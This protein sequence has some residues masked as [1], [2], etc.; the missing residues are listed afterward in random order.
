M[1]LAPGLPDVAIDPEPLRQVLGNL[2]DNAH[3]A[4]AGR[5]SLV[6]IEA[7]SVELTELE[8]PE[9]L[10]TPCRAPV[11]VTVADNGPGL[12]AVA[13]HY[14]FREPFFT[15]KPSHRGLGLAATYGILKSYGGGI[16]LESAAQGG[17]IA[18]IYLPVAG[19]V[20]TPKRG[21]P[22]ALEP[23]MPMTGPAEKMPIAD[24][25]PL[26]PNPAWAT[27]EEAGCR[28]GDPVKQPVSEPALVSSSQ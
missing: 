15:T 28:V 4:C 14:L 27:L 25:D 6:T 8:V 13:R 18:R 7:R 17:T 21:M 5:Q 16:R 22:M 19:S 12:G 20:A 10:G 26:I 11:E 3:E 1:A 9:L 2:L 23:G 24:D